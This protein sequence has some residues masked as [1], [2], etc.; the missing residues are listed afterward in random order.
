[1]ACELTSVQEAACESGIGTVNDPV[2]LLQIIAQ[3]LGDI[4][5]ADSPA[6]PITPDAIME[7]ACESG[8]GKVN[9]PIQLEQIIAQLLC[10]AAE[11][12][13]S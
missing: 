8:I 6:T 11:A 13:P 12:P 2:M 1:M 9:S 10:D 3:L 4:L 7:R 5:Q